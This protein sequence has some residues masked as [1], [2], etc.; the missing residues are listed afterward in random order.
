MADREEVIGSVLE[1]AREQVPCLAPALLGEDQVSHRTQRLGVLAIDGNCLG[2]Q[3]L[4]LVG[5]PVRLAQ[6]SPNHP[7]RLRA[8]PPPHDP[9]PEPDQ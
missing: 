4:G 5:V 6:Q 1:V 9:E 3:R 2:Q 7:G 8:L